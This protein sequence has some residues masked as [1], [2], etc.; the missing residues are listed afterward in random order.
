MLS[1]PDIAAN[2][3]SV[4]AKIKAAA[5]AAGRPPATLVAVTKTQ[6]NAALDAILAT[7]HTVF[8]ENRVQEAKAHWTDR[9][10]GLILHLIGPLQ[11]NKSE[12]AVALFDVIE[13]LDRPKLCRTLAAA[14]QK[15]GRSP[16]MLIQV[17][18]G[19][20]PQKA[21]IAPGDL[22]AFL[23]T[24]AEHDISPSGLMCIP[25]IDQSAGAHFQLL[26]TLAAR[27]G[28]KTLSMGMS[29][30]YETGAALGA[31]HVRVGSGIFGPRD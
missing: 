11:S 28:L 31:T 21:G 1:A 6:D 8:G 24:C 9:R 19:Q 4:Q 7:D 16:D 14:V 3:A 20:E 15:L 23:K 26:A 25:P 30:D 12:D 29:A 22:G 17:N 27:H 10:D 18:T 2:Y 5:E 13:T